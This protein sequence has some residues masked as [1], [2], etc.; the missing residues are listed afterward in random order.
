MSRCRDEALESA[1]AARQQVHYIVHCWPADHAGMDAAEVLAWSHCENI[2]T[3][4]TESVCGDN[5]CM[6]VIDGQR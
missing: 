6:W 5:V 2:S 3:P 4:A 1:T